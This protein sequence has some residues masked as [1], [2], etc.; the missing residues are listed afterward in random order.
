MVARDKGAT[1][2]S[3]P[4]KVILLGEH[5][6]VYGRPAIAVPVRDVRATVTV[7]DERA[8]PGVTIHASDIGR[9][10]E[11][12][13]AGV[14]V[15]EPLCTTVR[16][17][18]AYLGVE[19]DS[20][21][22]TLSI[23]SAIPVA[24][25]LGSGA[26]VATAIVRALSE[27]VGVSLDPAA[28]SAIVYET[29][30]IYHGTP[31]GVDNTVVAFEQPVYFCRGRPIEVLNVG[32]PF[33]LAIADTGVPGLTRESVADVRAAWQGDRATYEGLFDQVAVLVDA[34]RAALEDGRVEALGPLMNDNQRLLRALDVS[35]SELEALIA[36][37]LQSGAQ[38]AKLSGGGRGG[39]AIALIEPGDAERERVRDALLAAG[40]RSVMV[41]EVA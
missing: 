36:A 12:T 38:G 16:N 22:W 34:A 11:V 41:T 30:R 28:V 33:W 23:R 2:A 35:S 19:L 32:Q 7:T 10:I 15:D 26:A 31:S 8:G 27:H 37:A 24:S 20:V 18:L 40:A 29:E 39:N 6:V 14:P 25:G 17:A 9:T 5:A 4:G 1:M 13:S 21:E 3:A